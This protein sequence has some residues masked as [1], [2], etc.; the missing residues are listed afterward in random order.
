MSEE[1]RDFSQWKVDQVY[2]IQEG[3]CWNCGANLEQTGFHREHING[4]N[5]DNSLSNLRLGCPKCHGA[6]YGSDDPYQKHLSVEKRV[7]ENLNTLISQALDPASKISGA[8][9]EKLLDAMTLTLKVSRNTSEVDY[10]IERTPPAIKL[11]R[12]YVENQ[13]QAD[14]YIEGFLDGVKK[15][16]STVKDNAI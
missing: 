1:R 8:S 4:N 10:G 15:T 16:L 2:E 14:K 3:C 9:L 11:R 6:T 5:N 7:L 12:G 13:L